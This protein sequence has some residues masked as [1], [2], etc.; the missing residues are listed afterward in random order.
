MT[1]LNSQV[2]SVPSLKF[3]AYL[4][5]T[6]ISSSQVHIASPLKLAGGYFDTG[7]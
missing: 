5:D 3:S 4:M 1:S 7:K 6:N 2:S